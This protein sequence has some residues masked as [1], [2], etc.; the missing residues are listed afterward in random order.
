MEP[1][2]V[3]ELL[4]QG[5]SRNLPEQMR[6]RILSR[7]AKAPRRSGRRLQLVWRSAFA[8]LLVAAVVITV[9][10]TV[11]DSKRCGRLQAL[12]ASPADT[13]IAAAIAQSRQ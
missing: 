7:V 3:E 10:C 12:M 9:F 5:L 1:E 11:S 13:R 6:G 8:A 4:R 2:R